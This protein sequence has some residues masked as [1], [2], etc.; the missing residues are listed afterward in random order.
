MKKNP[1]RILATLCFSFHVCSMAPGE[2]DTFRLPP[3]FESS[4]YAGDELAHDIHTLTV[5]SRGRVV[6]A[7]KG[8]V[9][10]L[11]DRDHDGVADEATLF[12]DGPAEG[13]RGLYF[14]GNDLICSGDRQLMRLHDR[15]GDGRADGTRET[16]LSGLS[17]GGDHAANGVVR[18]PDGWFYHIGGNDAGYSSRQLPA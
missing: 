13:A 6:V 9:K 1:I 14:D 10:I 4:L 17:G 2:D 8:Y 7:G 16:L 15:D 18:G 11:H 3:G 12:T 5:D